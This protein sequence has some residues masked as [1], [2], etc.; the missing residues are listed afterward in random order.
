MVKKLLKYELYAYTRTLLPV[1]AILLGI[2]A[3]CR[4]VQF[5]EN[6]HVSYGILFWS[7]VTA[8]IITVIACI[9][10]TVGYGIV[11]FYKNLFSLEGYLSFTLPV[12]PTAHLIAKTLGQFIFCAAAVA[13]SLVSVAIATAGEVLVEIFRAGFWLIGE[14]FEKCG[15][16]A[17][18]YTLEAL[19]LLVIIVVYFYLM[20]CACISVGQTAKKNRILKAFGAY[21]VWYLITQA[22]GTVGI[23]VFAIFGEIGLLEAIGR[24]I[25]DYPFEFVH[26][27][28]VGAFI[29]AAAIS[30]MFFFISHRI[31]S[32]RLNLE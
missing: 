25:E 26:V 10:M 11:R 15:G 12:T 14:F 18:F 28:M 20:C 16:H 7:S 29:I 8:L 27:L 21:F 22:V 24:V 23:I 17:A 3:L 31:M 5:F 9:G 6:D 1:Y 2:S 32:R 19:L 13:V 30:A 4:F